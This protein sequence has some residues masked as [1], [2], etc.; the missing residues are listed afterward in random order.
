MTGARSPVSATFEESLPF[1]GGHG[2]IELALFGSREVQ[3]VIQ[4]TIAQDPAQE[5]AGF[6]DLD[7]FPEGRGYL[8]QVLRF[9]QIADEHGRWFRLVLDSVQSGRDDRG[10][11]HV[12][13]RVRPGDA[14]LAA[15]GVAAPDDTEARGAIVEGPADRRRSEGASY[16]ALVGIDVGGEEETLCCKSLSEM[17]ALYDYVMLK[18]LGPIRWK[19]APAE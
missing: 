7:R 14:A 9:V 10:E 1:P 15:Q 5:R 17:Q 6:R 2:R 12:R 8:L 16:E 4:H 11:G 19:A 3:V 18:K 13:I